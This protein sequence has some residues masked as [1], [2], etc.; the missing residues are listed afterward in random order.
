MPPV[1][2]SKRSPGSPRQCAAGG[3][4]AVSYEDLL[5]AQYLDGLKKERSASQRKRLVKSP[6]NPSPYLQ[7]LAHTDIIGTAAGDTRGR[8]RPQSSRRPFSAAQTSS[9]S[10]R[11]RKRI[12]ARFVVDPPK[13]NGVGE[14]EVEEKTKGKHRPASAPVYKSRPWSGRSA[15]SSMSTYSQ[16]SRGKMLNR[17]QPPVIRAMCYRNGSREKC[18]KITAPTMKIFLEYCTL[19]LDFEFAARRIFLEDGTEVKGAEEI[20]RDGEVYISGGEPFKNPFKPVHGIVKKN[21]HAAWTLDG[22]V[23]PSNKKKT[24]TTL[25]KR[26]R[27]MLSSGM[28]R[29][30]VFINGDAAESQEVVANLEQFNQFLDSCT[31]KLNLNSPARFIYT[32]DG[33]KLED[34]NDLPRLDACLQSSTTPIYGPV[35]VSKGERFSALGAKTFL[36]EIVKICKQQTKMHKT[37][38][39]ELRQ[40][41]QAAE[42]RGNA[43]EVVVMDKEITQVE[44]LIED[45]HEARSKMDDILDSISDKA[46]MEMEEGHTF[47]SKHMKEL[48]S[49][50]RLVGQ[51]GI[52]LKVYE[53]GRNDGE[54]TVF[55][56]MKEAS[57][58]VQAEQNLL[59][60]RLLDTITRWVRPEQNTTALSTIVTKIFNNKGKE[61]TNVYD[62][63]N[64]QKVW[65]S[66]GEPYRDPHV[67]CLQ[68]T[69]DKAIG[70]KDYSQAYGEPQRVVVR[71]P[72]L[73]DQIP[74]GGERHTSWMI[75]DMYPEEAFQEINEDTPLELREKVKEDMKVH[76]LHPD[77]HFLQHED[78]ESLMLYPEVSVAEKQKSSKVWPVRAQSWCINK[79]GVIYSKSH[80][81]L[82]LTLMLNR[83]PEWEIDVKFPG[84]SNE[85]YGI[86]VCLLER[87]ERMDGQQWVFLNDG[88]I[89]N[90]ANQSLLLTFAEAPSSDDQQGMEMT[91]SGGGGGGNEGISASDWLGDN[92]QTN[93][94]EDGYGAEEEEGDP[95]KPG[96]K[97]HKFVLLGM[98]RLSDKHRWAKAQRWA[99]KQENLDRPREWR[100]NDLMSTNPMWNKLAYSWPVDWRGD[101]NKNFDWPMEGYFIAYAPPIRTKSSVGALEDTNE[102]YRTVPL[103]LRVMK[104]GEKDLNRMAYVVGPDLTNMMKDLNRTAQNGKRPHR[105]RRSGSMNKEDMAA[106]IKSKKVNLKQLEFQLFLDKCTPQLNLPFAARRLFNENGKEL[107]TLEDLDRD[108]LVYV[109]S[110]DSWLNPKLTTQQQQRRMLLASLAGDID[111]I[112][113]Y[114]ALRDPGAMC[115]EVSGALGAGSP[116][117][118]N[119]C[120]LS[121]EDR[122]KLARG[123]TP[124]QPQ[125]EPPP[126]GDP[127]E[128]MSAH[129]KAHMIADQKQEGLK[130]PWEK[131]LNIGLEEVS[132]ANNQSG[133]EADGYT[134]P[135]L[136][137][138]LKPKAKSPRPANPRQSHQRFIYMD[139]Y[140]ACK[141]TPYLV[142]GPLD[143]STDSSPVVICK[144]DADNAYLR[145]TIGDDGLIRCKANEDLVLT[146]SLPNATPGDGSPPPSLT[147]QSVVLQPVK[148]E[149]NGRAN[150][151]WATE[152]E[153]GFI[154]G[155]AA[156]FR[157]REITAANRANVCTFAIADSEAIEQPGYTMKGNNKEEPP[158]T[159]CLACSRT[160]RAQYKLDKLSQPTSFS[161]SVGVAQKEGQ[162]IKGCLQFLGGKVDLSAFEATNTVAHYEGELKRLRQM[163]SARVIAR[164]ISAYKPVQTVRIVAYKNGEGRN[165]SGVIV[166]GS[167]LRGLLDQCTYALQLPTAGR[168]IYTQDGTAILTLSDLHTWKVTCYGMQNLDLGPDIDTKDEVKMKRAITENLRTELFNRQPVEVWV[169]QG[170]PFKPPEQV[171]YARALK[172]ELREE[173][174][175]VMLE[176]EKEKH[177][178]RQMQGR[179]TAGQ[180]IPEYVPT[181][182]PDEPVLVEG[183]WTKPSVTEVK[184]SI[185]VNQLENHLSEVKAHQK[186]RDPNSSTKPIIDSSRKLY[187]QP[188]KKRVMV[189]KNGT[190]EDQAQYVWGSSLEEILTE[191]TVKLGLHKTATQLYTATGGAVAS[192]DDVTR[193]DVLCVSYKESFKGAKGSRNQVEVKANWSRARKRDGESATDIM[194]T[195]N[196]H[197]NIEVDPFGPPALALPAPGD[198]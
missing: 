186:S 3:M 53:N 120:C 50:H 47:K 113:M 168:R 154:F 132:D 43:G 96:F 122:E 162:K 1:H 110:G 126:P 106:K 108:A 33:Q 2:V 183:G 179:R 159:V 72:L 16:H 101:I 190:S 98:E 171:D 142:L 83:G 35:W 23:L 29:V 151:I 136:Y 44:T 187:S 38:L 138:K 41:R 119:S 146:C 114:C 80:P 60:Q 54:E 195:A 107:T 30:M 56:N 25:S 163:T 90:W 133:G 39:G 131:V 20:P 152:K 64:D 103:R 116:L 24:K 66:F 75:R 130:W 117:I 169:S 5:V 141:T 55:F 160:L 45:F 150:Q 71:E 172:A 91:L 112:K 12:H 125:D 51:Q 61:I 181:L 88:R 193:D 176:L 170:E 118:V 175:K 147:G 74:E 42:D 87:E 31:S 13:Q 189:Y 7:R 10:E 84:S 69:L 46:A 21:M 102:E 49:S 185:Q 34:L 111:A 194:I 40:G 128:N 89:A 165:Q 73:A 166:C 191:A 196:T 79:D 140:I 164:E 81:K 178:L 105:H 68:L 4:D 92:S 100:H 85:T 173:R 129:Q 82:A 180:S 11:E 19:K 115:L 157:D 58:G 99:L 22:V 8:P 62:L 18:V 6:K 198:K 52:R 135:D 76:D 104:N 63:K 144:K 174:A 78:D 70:Y 37:R 124:E 127:Y 26:M 167:T 48:D 121:D 57:K 153:T 65:L 97:G 192:F 156:E 9:R 77:A 188:T 86:P 184:K 15:A 27:N 139:G 36:T 134:N 123:P 14:E 59:M 137:H 155:M 109:S 32:W 182:S 197:P 94:W 67:Y 148:P 143:P 145:W 149:K 17:L 158:M 177:V 95:P 93:Q 28:R 161:C